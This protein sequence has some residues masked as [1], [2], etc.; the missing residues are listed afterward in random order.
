MDEPGSASPDVSEQPTLPG[1]SAPEAGDAGLN[2][3]S[4]AQLVAL[5]T[6]LQTLGLDAETILAQHSEGTISPPLSRPK[7]ADESA[8]LS[9]QALR[10]TGPETPL[11]APEYALGATLGEG[12][13]GIVRVARQH[14]LERDVAI[15]S[16]KGNTNNAALALLREAWVMGRLEHPNVVPIHALGRDLA[17]EPAFV[18]KRIE[19]RAWSDLIADPALLPQ[20]AQADTLGW[21]LGVLMQVCNA[22]A[23]AH[24]RG[25]L[26][27]D[28]K[29]DNVMVGPFGEVYVLDWGLAVSIGSDEARI[30]KAQDINAIAGTLHY[31]A[32]EMAAGKG[33]GIDAHTD[34]YLLGTLLH[35]VLTG[36]PRHRGHSPME[37]LAAAYHS[38]PVSYDE[39][40]AP[41][42]AALANRATA[43]DPGARFE[44]AIAFHDAIGEYLQHRTSLELSA[45]ASQRLTELKELIAT[46]D[47]D[48]AEVTMVFTA[49]RFCYQMA[50]DSWSDN[51]A[52]KAGLNEALTRMV[53]YHLA[54]GHVP[55]ARGLVAAIESPSEALL[56]ELAEGEEAAKQAEKRSK[57]LE[58]MRQQM[59]S[60]IGT[61]TRAFMAF[62]LGVGFSAM[63]ALVMGILDQQG[64]WAAGHAFNFI[65]AAIFL[66]AI[67]GGR[68]WASE[69]ITATSF[70]RRASWSLASL[71]ITNVLLSGA[72]YSTGL[73]AQSALLMCLLLCG[74]YMALLTSTMD[75]RLWACAGTYEVAFFG[76]LLWPEFTLYWV[77]AGHAA[78]GAL[79]AWFWRPASFSGAYDGDSRKV[80]PAKGSDLIF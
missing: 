31:M 14:S 26:H 41:E 72:V 33:A 40:I 6:H 50:L 28:L 49:S 45:A 71:G 43:H 65:S 54:A 23:F 48:H 35:Q 34:V 5:E 47:K 57:R 30:P 66:I 53:T 38:K 4:T 1:D 63:P 64:I 44:S 58:H 67:I 10:M 56:A 27:R 51:P 7:S 79:V 68:I 12:G 76:A 8:L 78:A 70:N 74:F 15:K 36:K 39:G 61:R 42:L 29:P 16:A 20:A 59:D 69:T 22:I 17:G 46:E 24:S 60:T 55:A 80:V 73:P 32:P 77:A 37:L 2:D 25:V 3:V 62:S 11:Q 21:H 19:G 75:K 52:A 9:L 18:M 13:M